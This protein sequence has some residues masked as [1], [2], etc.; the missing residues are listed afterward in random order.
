MCGRYVS[1]DEAAMERYWHIGARHSGRW[2]RQCFNV[3]PTTTVPIVRNLAG[4]I[5][6]V[7]ARWGLI[8]GWWKDPR[9]PGMSFVARSED[10]ANKPL[11][12]QSYRTQRCLLPA[13]GWYEWCAH[14]QTVT[15]S[16]RK[17][18][19]PYYLHAANDA[20]IAIAGLWASWRDP[21]GQEVVSCALLTREA[22]PSIHAIHPRM[23]VVLAP[24][25]FERWLADDQ[26]PA[27]LDALLHDTR[28]D[29]VG[30]AVSTRVNNTHNDG[31]EL[32]DE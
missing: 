1:P 5:E 16:G 27:T 6:V 13:Q 31:P 28:E 20:L 30:H 23:P 9:P 25:Q 22:V 14:E 21:D 7:P 26:P 18:N 12:R 8:P 11:W 29:F 4:E 10:A 19:Q 15:S 24:H 3:A 32:L 17:T 2:I